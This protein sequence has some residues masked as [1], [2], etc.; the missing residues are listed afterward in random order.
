MRDEEQSWHPSLLLMTEWKLQK[1]KGGGGG[2]QFLRLKKFLVNHSPRSVLETKDVAQD[3][4]KGFQVTFF[5][6]GVQKPVHQYKCLNL[7]G[8]CME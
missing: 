3:Y 7:C 1:K 4:L 8:N 6:K 5:N 2:S